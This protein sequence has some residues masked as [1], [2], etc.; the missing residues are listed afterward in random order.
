MKR[1]SR[2]L[3]VVC[4]LLA[5]C[6]CALAEEGLDLTRYNDVMNYIVE[7]QPMALDLGD[8]KF[9][10]GQLRKLKDAMPEGAELHFNVFFR[11]TWIDSRG[12]IIDLDNSSK[13]TSEADLLWLLENMPNVTT[14][15]LFNHREFTNEFMIPLMEQY[16]QITFGWQVRISSKYVVRSDATAFSTNKESS[17]KPDLTEKQFENLKYVPGLKAIDIGH[18]AVKDISW[19]RNFPELNILILADNQVSDISPLADLPELEYLEIFMNYVSDYSPLAG[20]ENLRDLNV[21]YQLGHA[22]DEADL[23]VLD[24][25]KLERF[26]CNHN[27][28]TE[29]E[30]QRF[31]ETH[32]DTLCDFSYSHSTADGWRESYKYGQFRRMFRERTW[33]PFERPE[34]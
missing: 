10:I 28:V 25:L 23:S 19:L 9:D 8:T 21:S 17:G 33:Y 7:A 14:V 30:A 11:Q 3:A 18:N 16:P 2:L 34:E 13:N 29:E 32:P 4:V 24:G 12:E 27:G 1:I 5:L 22:F 6:A 31:R 26:W 20:L 15:N